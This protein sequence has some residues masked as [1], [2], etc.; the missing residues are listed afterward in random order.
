MSLRGGSTS[1]DVK[2]KEK[3]SRED[4]DKCGA[5]KKLVA[6][7]DQGL[8]CE[9]C[10]G[11]YHAK[12]EKVGGEAYAV[13][14]GSEA[15]HWYC[16]G[17]NKGV[18]KIL[19]VLVEVQARQDKLEKELTSVKQELRMVKGEIQ[20]VKISTG[21]RTTKDTEIEAKIEETAMSVE[22][23]KKSREENETTV[24]TGL[25]REDVL[26][27][28]EI[29]KRR[30][31][32]VIMGLKDGNDD[33]REIKDL[34]ECLTGARGVKAIV[35]FERFGRKVH[36]KTRPLRVTLLNWDSKSELLYKSIGLRDKEEYKKVYISPDLT[37]RQQEADKKLRDKFRELKGAGEQDIKIKKG[38]II[39][40]SDGRVLYPLPPM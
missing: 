35:N 25:M 23:L 16:A 11:W 22:E 24:K 31:N 4:G 32:V 7:T 28:I 29:E 17:C 34:F 13:L 15:L 8:Q 30:L 20:Q 36:G 40:N 38:K 26:E 21:E 6:D 27:E 1:G 18:Q 10:E 37:R 19:R 14:Q 12:C 3:E 33:E 39:K 2:A 5:C 9:I